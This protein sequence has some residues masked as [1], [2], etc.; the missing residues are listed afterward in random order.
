M[1]KIKKHFFTL[2][3]IFA[4]VFSSFALVACDHEHSYASA[5]STDENYHWHKCEVED[6]E[7]VSDKAE[8]TAS[9][10]ILD[11][12]QTHTAEGA[13]H[14]ECTV[15]GYV[16]ETETIAKI[17]LATWNG[18]VGTVPNAVNDVIEISTAEQLAG[19]ASEVNS[20]NT[21]A[22]YTVKLVI[23]IDLNNRDWTPIGRVIGYPSVSFSGVFDG[24]GHTIYNLK[25]TDETTEDQAT[26]GLFGSLNGTIKN[27]NLKNVNVSSVHYASALVGYTSGNSSVAIKNCHIDNA[28]IASKAEQKGA[29]YDNGDKVGGIIG[30]GNSVAVENCSIKNAEISG[31]RDMGGIIGCADGG[32][33]IKN[34][35]IGENVVITVDNTHNYKNYTSNNSY[36]VSSVVGR[37]VGTV[38]NT[39]NT[40][41][42]T[43]NMPY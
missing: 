27:L 4:V 7:E 22:N 30:Y 23:D 39:G 13:K 8:H 11:Q 25:V 35:V 3:L 24:D 43:I 1:K 19:L 21:Y 2:A 14:K 33:S 26:A 42:A 38:E 20:G 16:M 36:N 10:W 18:T 34:N 15:C 29:G 37:T 41:T 9:D 12:G 31:Y 28:I 32:C 6:C 40:G 17:P 5:W